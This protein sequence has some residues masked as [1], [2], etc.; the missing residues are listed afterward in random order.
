[1]FEKVST[2][3]SVLDALQMQMIRCPANGDADV[4]LEELRFDT[5]LVGVLEF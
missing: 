1:M 4:F 2:E 5:T 3:M